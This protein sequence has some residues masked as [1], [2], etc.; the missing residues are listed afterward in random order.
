MISC[1]RS[2]CYRRKGSEILCHAFDQCRQLPYM[3]PTT[4]ILCITVCNSLPRDGSL[5]KVLLHIHKRLEFGR[6]D[7]ML[8]LIRRLNCLNALMCQVAV[9]LNTGLI[10]AVPSK[11]A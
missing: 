7:P 9:G 1:I 6:A 11:E 4:N 5:P 3:Y 8:I 10:L 2:I